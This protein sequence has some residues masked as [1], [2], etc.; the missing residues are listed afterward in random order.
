VRLPC[1]IKTV[2]S[3]FYEVIIMACF[4]R[5]TWL[6]VL[7]AV[8]AAPGCGES[9]DREALTKH[10]VPRSEYD[11]LSAK[12]DDLTKRLGTVMTRLESVV[13]KEH[14]LEERLARM[15]DTWNAREN[16]TTSVVRTRKLEIVD[17]KGTVLAVAGP[18][19]KGSGGAF[20][21][22]NSAGRSIA[23]LLAVG[24]EGS[25]ACVVSRQDESP[26]VMMDAMNNGK[27]RLSVL[28]GN[29]KYAAWISTGDEGRGSLVLADSAGNPQI[30]ASTHETAGQILMKFGDND[31]RP[32]MTRP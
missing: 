17:D 24:D 8:L 9:I 12:A 6:S 1:N 23:K 19:P 22:F 14:E 20:V 28:N 25:G 29:G 31:I 32:V 2:W 4:R 10:L 30:M 27:S 26:A 21:V 18:S 15:N 5:G 3:T 13:A 16:R 11:A 7:I